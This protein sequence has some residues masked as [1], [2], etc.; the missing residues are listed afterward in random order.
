MASDIVY[1]NGEYLPLAD[2]KIS[3]LDRG[4]LFGD[5]VYEVIPAYNGRLFRPEEH[6][7][8]L[9]N[10]LQGIRLPLARSN[11]EWLA[12]LNP[13]L[14]PDEPDQSVY[15]QIT[16]GAAPKRDHAFPE[17]V[18]PTVFAM[19]TPI[20]YFAG[21]DSG[22]KAISVEDNRWQLCQIKAIT[23][24]AN[25]LLRQQA[26]DHDCAEALLVKNG[27]VTEGSASNVFAVLDGVLTTPPKD[28]AILPGITRDVIVEI[29]EREGIPVAERPIALAEL[30]DAGEIWFTSSTRE[31]MPV[32]ELDG[33]C[34]AD[35]KPGPLFHKMNALFQQ[36]KR[37]V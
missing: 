37:S 5:G 8:R 10:S 35:G 4:F 7:R 14:H 1:L 13:L 20:K 15:L 12:I 6:L 31:I 16:R 23:L 9:N 30:R 22:V 26:V 25:V 28:G 33:R 17:N 24:L 2:A 3:V 21:K 19:C 27:F 11:A 34:V 29:A 18:A 36:F 32:I